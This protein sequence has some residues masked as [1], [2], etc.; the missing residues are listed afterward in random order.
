M[1]LF[2]IFGR[3]II[4]DILKTMSTRLANSNIL[5]SEFHKLLIIS[6]SAST[7]SK[8]ANHLAEQL[9]GLFPNNTT[10]RLDITDY[11]ATESK[12]KISQALKECDRTTLIAVCGGDGT[13]SSVIACIVSLPNLASRSA[14]VLPL[15]GG[16]ANDL[17]IMLNGMVNLTTLEKV[18]QNA[19]PVP[20]YP[21]RILFENK[22]YGKQGRVATNY[23]SFGISAQ[24]T[25]L[26][27]KSSHQG[28]YDGYLAPVKR[29]AGEIS[30]VLVT[31]KGAKP[32][33]S[34]KD[35]HTTEKQLYEQVFMNGNRIAKIPI[36]KVALN[37]KL[38][39]VASTDK[40]GV[41]LLHDI[42]KTFL[43]K[44]KGKVTNKPYIFTINSETK[45]Q[46]D[47]E[48]IDI[49]KDTKV[50]VTINSIP[51]LALSQKLKKDT[52]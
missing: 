11:S 10:S 30:D 21:L 19:R 46:I 52:K 32:F 49:H 48:I 25:H 27:E 33:T 4:S 51:F 3:L 2:Y 23:V 47:G 5:I 1:R 7:N 8:R 22:V 15:W 35:K 28:S 12:Q 36:S 44:T 14:V 29:V 17:A 16:N 18:L 39:F 9:R 26:M 37:E 43:K 42:Y 20:I 24:A 38:Y 31:L 6:N 50:T 41:P 34:V 13:V 45:C 40:K